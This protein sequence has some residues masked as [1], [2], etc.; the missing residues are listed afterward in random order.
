MAKEL[1]RVASAQREFEL[2]LKELP[3]ELLLAKE[4]LPI[5]LLLSIGL[6]LAN[7][8]LQIELLL[9]NE[10][11]SNEPKESLVQLPGNPFPRWIGPGDPG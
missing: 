4:L 7:E 2:L 3:K 11:L 10:L 6:L 5:E 1:P 9:A 8:L